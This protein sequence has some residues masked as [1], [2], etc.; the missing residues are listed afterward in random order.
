MGCTDRLAE[1]SPLWDTA[2]EEVVENAS[3]R[4]PKGLVVGGSEIL[5]NPLSVGKGVEAMEA[6]GMVDSVKLLEG[7]LEGPS[8]LKAAGAEGKPL[9]LGLEDE[10][11]DS[12][13]V[14]DALGDGAV[15]MLIRGDREKCGDTEDEPL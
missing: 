13:A 3:E 5:I 1:I 7:V 8:A 10:Q 14:F 15:V 4:V 9:V 12:P 6:V 2:G 11:A